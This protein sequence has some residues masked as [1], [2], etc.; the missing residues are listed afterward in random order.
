[1]SPV[2]ALVIVGITVVAVNLISRRSRQRLLAKQRADWGKPRN[3]S[4][5]MDAIAEYHHSIVEATGAQA[6]LDR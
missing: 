1:M 3:R 6:S 2:L 5:N 4:R